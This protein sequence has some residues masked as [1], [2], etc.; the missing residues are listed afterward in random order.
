MHPEASTESSFITGSLHADIRGAQSSLIAGLPSLDSPADDI[1]TSISRAH[2]SRLTSLPTVSRSAIVEQ[3][4]LAPWQIK[5]V[6]SFVASNF[7]EKLR[8]EDL[9]ACA[10]LSMSYFAVAFKRSF[11]VTPHAYITIHRVEF[12]K[13][14]LVNSSLTLCTIALDC[15]LADQSHFSRVFRRYTGMTPTSWRKGH[16]TTSPKSRL[17]D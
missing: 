13:S 11:G 5:R 10:K 2:V 12:A 4:G 9:A 3:G 7:R 6:S 16:L 14:Q 17:L 15:G 8:L 1:R